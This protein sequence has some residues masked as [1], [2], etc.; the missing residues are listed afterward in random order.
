MEMNGLLKAALEYAKRG[1]LVLPLHYPNGEICSCG[2]KDCDSPGKHPI[3]QLTP[4]GFKD[5][6]SDPSTIKKWW[7]DWPKANI[8]IRTGA[9]SDLIVLDIDDEKIAVR[10][11]SLQN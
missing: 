6:T 7:T 11:T 4:H 2:K 10:R 9:D 1:W 8:G 5:A 3:G